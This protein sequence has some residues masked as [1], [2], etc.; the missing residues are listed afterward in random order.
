MMKKNITQ[1]MSLDRS[2]RAIYILSTI[3][4]GDHIIKEQRCVDDKGRVSWQ[5]LTNTGV[6]L[7]MDERKEIIITM[8]I[9]SQP[10]VSAMYEGK[11]PS[12]VFNIVRKN[13]KHA[14]MQN[15]VR[16]ENGKEIYDR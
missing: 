12:W 6:L 11:T 4:M 13:R 3:G 16:Y 14:E 8:Y 1:H 10:K 15:K 9:A 7:V 5:C 2:D